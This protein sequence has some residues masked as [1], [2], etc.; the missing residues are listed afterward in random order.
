[1][2]CYV[3]QEVQ[4]FKTVGEMEKFLLEHGEQIVDVLGSEVDRIEDR[5]KV[6]VCACWSDR[7]LWLMCWARLR[8]KLEKSDEQLGRLD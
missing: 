4:G 8:V 6:S 1:M 2:M 7:Q 3:P 5:I